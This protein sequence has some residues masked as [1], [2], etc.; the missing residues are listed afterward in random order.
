M[1]Q[2]LE[3]AYGQATLVDKL[4]Y[5][6]IVACAVASGISALLYSPLR[7]RNTT[8]ATTKK[9]VVYS[10]IRAG[11]GSA[12]TAQLQ[13]ASPQTSEAYI[14]LALKEG[15]EAQTI[16]HP[17]TT[18]KSHWLGSASA[19]KVLLYF[20]GGGYSL[21]ATPAHFEYLRR[22]VKH[23]NNDPNDGKA[24]AVLL[25]AYSL[26]PE[27]A[28]PTPLAQASECLQYLLE[29]TGRK[30]SSIIIGGDSAG[31]NL[32]LSLMSHAMHPH[33]EL[34]LPRVTLNSPLA[35]ALLISPW[36]EFDT[37]KRSSFQ[38]NFYLDVSSPTALASWTPG[39]LRDRGSDQYIEPATAG[40]QWWTGLEKCA[41][42]VLIWGGGGEVLID[43]IKVVME[44]MKRAAPEHVETVIGHRMC[45]EQMVVDII[46]GNPG[47]EAE[48]VVKTWLRARLE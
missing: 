22:L 35:G 41:D 46:L 21:P 1:V 29:D 6:Y 40:T 27:A 10:M 5:L 25:L 18:C 12:N 11:L 26:V 17:L 47:G 33:P 34:S 7:D 36:V 42:Q 2:S 13:Y 14:Q 4:G 44:D 31:G 3:R 20:H 37:T 16:E 43:G 30:P 39:I 28:Y 23:I 24:F 38:D 48:S 9:H 32:C 15:F 19:R 45:H 8:P